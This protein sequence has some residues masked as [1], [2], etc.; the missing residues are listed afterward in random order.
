MYRCRLMAPSTRT[1]SLLPH[2]GLHP[3]P[4][5]TGHDFHHEAWRRH[6]SASPLAYG[7]PRPDHHC[8][9]GRTRTHHARYSVSIVWGPT[10]VPPPPLRAASPVLQ[11]EPRTSGW[12]SRPISGGQKPSPNGLNW[13][14]PPKS[15]D[16]LHSQMRSRDEAVRSAHLEQLPVFLWRGDYHGTS[17]LP[18][19][20]FASLSVASQNVA[21]ASL[22]HPQ[23]WLLLAEN[24]HLPTA[25]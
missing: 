3:I 2:G 19:M 4:W 18:L 14:P 22:R 23:I 8:G 12:T 17:M 5:L 15:A 10:L 13:H 25:W 20:W 1:S 16:H 6:Q 11:S 9:I 7:A 24:C 21:Y